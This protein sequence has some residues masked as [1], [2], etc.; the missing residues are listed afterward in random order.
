MPPTALDVEAVRADFPILGTTVHGRRLVYLDSAASSQKPRQVIDAERTFY[1]TSYANIHRGVYELSARATEAYDESRVR[2][3]RYLGA[4]HPHEIIFTRGTTDGINLVAQSFVRPRLRPGD[5]ILITALEHHSNI[6]P[7]QLAADAT[8]AVLRVA[9]VSE[10]GELELD[11]F[12]ALIGPKTRFVAV[13]HVSNALGTVNPVAAMIEMAHAGGVPVLLDGA[14]AAPHLPV[15][16]AGLGADFFACSAHKMYGPTGIGVLYGREELLDAMPPV[17]GGGDMIATVTFEKST[18][19]P[20]PAKFEAGTPHIAGAVGLGA[21]VDYIEG[22][23]RDAVAA[24]EHELLTYAT[25]RLADLPGVTVVGQA[26]EKASVLSFTMSGIHPHDIGTVLDSVG[27]CVR[28]GH[29]CAQP[30]MQRLGLVATARASF[31]A[32]NTRSDVDALADGLERV[33]AVFA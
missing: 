7:W 33:R 17:Q 27:V 1:E 30:L 12:E 23:G 5:E 25:A 32:Y 15:D 11:A 2:V 16:L 21:A 14:Q 10:R 8:G 6:V 28:A 4:R 3:A 22:L 29:H 19:A 26:S 18:W 20:L 13:A 24:H 31:A 9:P